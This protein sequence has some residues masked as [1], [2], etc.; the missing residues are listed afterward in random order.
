M[1][2]SDIG[3]FGLIDRISLQFSA[4][5]PPGA[6]G[7]GDDC[8]VIERSG[9]ES[10]LITTDLL[11]EDVHFLRDRISAA[12]LGYKSL[13]VNLSDIAA[14][15]GLA[16]G[17][18]LSLALP[19]EIPLEWI[20]D[21]YSG[22]RD[23]SKSSSTPLLGGDTTRSPGRIIINFA[24]TGKAHPER[25][26]YR[27]TAEVD[28]VIC[29]TGKLGDSAGGLK[30]LLDGLDEGSDEDL[31]YLVHAHHK[32]RPHLDEGFYLAGCDGVHAMIDLSDGIDSDI[33]QI[34][35]LSGTGAEIDINRLPLSA[36]LRKA[37]D[38]F[39]WDKY[40][41]AA[42]GGED[43]CLLCTIDPD[44]FPSIRDQF[45]DKFGHPLHDIGQINGGR[46]LE[47]RDRN[48]KVNFRK[49]GWDSFRR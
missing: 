33:G 31:S 13:A 49:G 34:N 5:I 4:D 37:S 7:I 1:K 28:D 3:E 30:V 29:V 20:D 8:A 12:E 44:A 35:K 26:K 17:A 14:M 40:E 46:E 10:L 15:G 18:F 43:Y 16:E 41:L 47:Y 11:I 2:L 19:E 36:P 38:R 9:E 39:G 45:R 25:I 32:P 22:I 6:V 27:S 42:A 24:V 48:R 23:L 21:F